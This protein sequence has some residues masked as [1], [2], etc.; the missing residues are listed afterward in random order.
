MEQI[1]KLEVMAAAWYKNAPHLPNE[2]RLWLARN[3]WWLTIVGIVLGSFGILTIVSITFFAGAL[4]A[5][6]AGVVGAVVGGFVLISVIISLLLAM[7]SIFI[8]GMA[9]SPLQKMHKKGWTLLF[10]ITLIEVASLG[11]SLIFTFDVFGTIWGLLWAA[12]GAYFLFEIR[13]YF[14]A[15]T[16]AK[17]TTETKS[18]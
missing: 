13:E 5:G 4:L 16:I 6:V 18:K 9:V 12:V 17:K 15:A 3:V 10:L 11:V 2:I 14:T 8:G 1:H 7:V